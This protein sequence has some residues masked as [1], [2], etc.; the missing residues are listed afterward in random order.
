MVYNIVITIP[1][2]A[3][4][5]FIKLST[6]EGKLLGI[7]EVRQGGQIAPKRLIKLPSYK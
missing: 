4:T 7:G 3:E 1:S 2:V 5:D 6:K